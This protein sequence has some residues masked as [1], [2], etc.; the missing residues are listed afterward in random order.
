MV[1]PKQETPSSAFRHQNKPFMRLCLERRRGSDLGILCSLK[2]WT[3]TEEELEQLFNAGMNNGRDK[4]DKEEANQQD[5]KDEDENR[6]ND[7]SEG[8][9]EKRDNKMITVWFV[10]RS[11]QALTSAQSVNSLFMLFVEGTVKTVRVSDWQSLATSVWGRIESTLSEKVQNPVRNNRIKKLF[12]SP[13]QDFQQL[14]SGQT[15]WSG[16]LTLIEDV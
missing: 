13:N 15:S 2:T 4:E 5:R 8:T 1:Y 6:T 11:D 10:R 16:C 9:V 3:E 12:L 14:I 7:T